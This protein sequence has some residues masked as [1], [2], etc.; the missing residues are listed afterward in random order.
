MIFIGRQGVFL[1]K[2][3]IIDKEG[4][5][6]ETTNRTNLP[7]L[8]KLKKS[9]RLE[10]EVFNNGMPLT[11][12]TDIADELEIHF[13]NSKYNHMPDDISLSVKNTE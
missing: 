8:E 13:R 4:N 7:K 6:V 5:H 11:N 3:I 9:E 12:P 2:V 10:Y 1:P